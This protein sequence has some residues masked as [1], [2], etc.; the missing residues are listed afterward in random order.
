MVKIQKEQKQIVAY[1]YHYK[2]K[3]KVFTPPGARLSDFISGLGQKKF[4]PV[5]D[6][7]VTDIFGNEICKTGFLE[8]NKDEIIFLLPES[9]L[10]KH[11]TR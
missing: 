1:P 8:L 10:E 5:V 2:I 7:V 11:K 9:E 6:A 3:G 4:I